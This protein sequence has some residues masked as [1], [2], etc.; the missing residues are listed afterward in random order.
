M[1]TA[2]V[3]P[4]RFRVGDEALDDLHRRLARVRLPDRETVDGWHQGVPI[5]DARALLDHWRT[6]HD[7]RAFE[8]RLD[9]LDQ[10]RTSID[11]VAI[12]FIHARSPHQHALPI[13]LTHGWPGSFI[14]FLDVIELLR[15]PERH[16]G[17]SEDAFHIVIPSLPG[18]GFSDAPRDTG[19]GPKRIAR[20]WGHLMQHLGYGRWV[21]QGGDWGS[22]VTHELA[23][24]RP[25]GLAAAHVNWP[26]VL[27]DP[28]PIRPNA[29][30]RI[31]L[32][33]LARFQEDGGGYFRQQATRPQ[34]IAYALADSPM[35]QATWIYEKFRAWVDPRYPLPLNRVLDTT[36]LYWFTN[37]AASSGRLY[38]EARQ[39]GS[40][41]SIGRI[42]L[43]MAA[44]IFP[45]EVWRAPREWA[46][47]LWPN[48][49]Y[50]NEVDRG[51]HFAAMEQP[52]LFVQELR[53]AF[54]RLRS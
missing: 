50:W 12:H 7:W 54:G 28:P 43:P 3:H 10:F 19:W 51:G 11:G 40:T 47:A 30:E 42:D 35:G 25:P 21:A 26:L 36:C 15:N 37:T 18:F 1:S 34:T 5:A 6:R 52:A 16:G 27:P 39:D 24:L 33:D 2:S 44:S 22:E 29:A 38:W 14:E 31:A 41:P 8:A 49:F 20:A 9:E 48:L 32:R 4:Y 53:A 45:H 23:K 46:A 13:L 17:R